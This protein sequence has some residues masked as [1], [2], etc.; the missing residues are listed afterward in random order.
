MKMRSVGAI[1]RE[2]MWD[3]LQWSEARKAK[4]RQYLEQ[5]VADPITQALI[6]ELGSAGNT[7]AVG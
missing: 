7:A 1:S 3:E 4:E 5:E 2:G 6:N